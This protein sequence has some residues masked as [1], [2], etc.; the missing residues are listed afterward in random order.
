MKI[1]HVGPIKH[2]R[3]AGGPSHSIRGLVGMQ[4]ELGL[5][6]GLISSLPLP[7]NASMEGVPGVYLFQNPRRAHYNPWFLPKKWIA[8]I[9]AEFGTP[10]LV[11]FHCFY[12]PF[13]CALARRCR[14]LG[15]P[16]I[17]TPRGELT[18]FAQNIKRTKKHIANLLCFFSYTKHAAAV[19]ALRP[20]EAEEIQT[21]FKVKRVIIVPN[22]VEDCL[23]EASDK[24]PAA[25]LGDFTHDGDLVL[26]FVGRIYVYHKGLDLLLKAMAILKSQLNGLACKL[27]LIGPFYK[28]E[29]EQSFCSLVESLGLKNDVKLLGPKYGEEKLRYVLACDVFVHTSRFEGMPMSVLEAMALGRPCLATPGTNMADVVCEGGGWQCQSDP[30][31]IAKSLKDIYQQRDSLRVRGRQSHEL[32]KAR[33]TWR[34]VAQQMSEE[35]AKIVKQDNT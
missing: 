22:G 10:D 15:W 11:H 29:D 27:F 2:I 21:L 14:K 33:F 31:S 23:L 16:Y 26:G 28:K 32:I 7:H 9:Q 18:Y 30:D 3:V 24:L 8:R 34:K 12:T 5:S 19:H 20:I 25:D 13:Q 35:Y 6:V 4:A 17:I 1:L